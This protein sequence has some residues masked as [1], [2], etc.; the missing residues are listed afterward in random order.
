MPIFEIALPSLKP[1]AALIQEVEE[2]FIPA[3]RPLFHDAGILNGLRGYFTS[4]DGRDVRDQFREVVVLGVYFISPYTT[5]L[6]LG[7]S[8]FLLLFV[9]LSFLPACE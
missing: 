5:K 4:E 3:L 1:D 7:S 8:F 9:T 6:P 2:K